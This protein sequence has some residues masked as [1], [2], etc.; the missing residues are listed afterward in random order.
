MQYFSYICITETVLFSFCRLGSIVVAS[1]KKGDPITA[2]DLVCYLLSI[3]D[4]TNS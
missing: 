4:A 1:D 3:R 2:D